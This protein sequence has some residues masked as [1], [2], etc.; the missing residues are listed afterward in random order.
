[1]PSDLVWSL[2]ME[3]TIQP[4]RTLRP[5]KAPLDGEKLVGDRSGVVRI[6][7]KAVAL[8][9]L[10]KPTLQP[11]HVICSGRDQ[12]NPDL[13]VGSYGGLQEVAANCEKASYSP[14]RTS[15]AST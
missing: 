14:S 10:R 2:S 3:T 12:L 15:T 7:D 9:Q 11:L 8:M 5:P 1:V 13:V 4:A 6:A